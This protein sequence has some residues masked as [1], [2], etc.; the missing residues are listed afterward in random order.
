MG[1][2]MAVELVKCSPIDATA[3]CKTREVAMTISA[4]AE[5]LQNGPPYI[6]TK[7]SNDT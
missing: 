1:Q 6:C 2:V 5:Q 7:A 4:D 3:A